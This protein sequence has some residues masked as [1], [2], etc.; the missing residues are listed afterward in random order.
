MIQHQDLEV[1]V[2]GLSNMLNSGGAILG[3]SLQ[4]THGHSNMDQSRAHSGNGSSNNGGSSSRGCQLEL[5]VKGHGTL[6]LYCNHVPQS[7]SADCGDLSYD[8]DPAC[9]KVT[10]ALTGEHLQQQVVFKW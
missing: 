3:C 10:V 5:T 1:A 8:N 2:V 7:V 4:S 9:G 6:M